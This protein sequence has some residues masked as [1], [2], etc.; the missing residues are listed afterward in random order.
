MPD[1]DQ[2]IDGDYEYT[3]YHIFPAAGHD[4][5]LSWRA[6]AGSVLIAV[7]EGRPRR[8]DTE[9]DDVLVPQGNRVMVMQATV[10]LVTKS[11]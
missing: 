4:R 1:G 8:T 6:G 11:A 2:T 7:R 10:R 9:Q 3:D 5:L